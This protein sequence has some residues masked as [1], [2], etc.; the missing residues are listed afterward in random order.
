M[1]ERFQ[2]LS[3]LL[4]Q[5]FKYDESFFLLLS[6]RVFHVHGIKMLRIP[7]GGGQISG[8]VEEMERNRPRACS[9]E[10]DTEFYMMQAFMQECPDGTD[11][12][13]VPPR[14]WSTTDQGRL[15]VFHG[16]STVFWQEENLT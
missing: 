15:I 9:E 4:L 1:Q 14:E 10:P 5:A 3:L 13:S 8:L 6:G 16:S 7:E 2:H 11:Y 12:V